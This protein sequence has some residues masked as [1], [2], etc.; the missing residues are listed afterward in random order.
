MIMK[1]VNWRT[2]VAGLCYAL[3]QILPAFGLPQDVSNAISTIA[4]F[5]LGLLAM[6]SKKQDT[7]AK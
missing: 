3:G 7:E 2:T 5:L 4:V 1:T 6:D